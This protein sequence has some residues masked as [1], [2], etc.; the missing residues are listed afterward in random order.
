M[1]NE[2]K[3]ANWTYDAVGLGHTNV[4]ILNAIEAMLVGTGWVRPVWDTALDRCFI[5]ADRLTILLTNDLFGVAGN[6]TITE[7]DVNSRTSVSGMSG[8]T[9]QTK[10]TGTLTLDPLNVFDGNSFTIS[11]G[12]NP[13]Q[14]FEFEA[15]NAPARGKIVLTAQP[16]DGNTVVI[17][18]GV[19]PAVTFEFDSNSSVVQTG[20]LR[21]VVIGGNISVTI[22]NLSAAINAVAGTLAITANVGPLSSVLLTN[23]VGGV[24]GNV[25]LV[26]VG[27]AIYVEGM[28]GGGGTVGVTGGAVSVP[29]GATVEESVINLVS[30]INVAP[31]L[32]ITARWSDRWMF[33]GDG[34][35]QH[36]GIHVFNDTANTR[37]IIRC[38]L[39][40]KSGYGIQVETPTAHQIVIAYANTAPNTF[41]FYAGEFGFFGECGRDG[42]KVNLA[43]WLIGSYEPMPEL[44]GT[45][46]ARVHWS[47]QGAPMDLF[48]TLKFTADRNMRFVGPGDRH[49]T[50]YL[51]PLLARGH[52]ASSYDAPS[53][54]DNP[55]CAV[56]PMD[57]VL[58]IQL[59]YNTNARYCA[60]AYSFGLNSTPRDGRYRIS[61]LL[62][63]Q[64]W[65]DWFY[66]GTDSNSATVVSPATTDSQAV[67]D[68]RRWRRVP[69][70]AVTDHTLIPF[71][72]ITD[73]VTGI[74]YYI[75]QV[76]DGG[77]S[78]NLAIEYTSD[79]LSIP[80][81]P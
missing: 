72:N 34:L 25:V 23:D 52:N 60:V 62:L 38:F 13:A 3:R 29:R 6:V 30:A 4:T 54:V 57:N 64:T 48:G 31:N 45:D 77:R 15:G 51:T 70:I 44:F 73:A 7:N 43:H 22:S 12:V 33:N 8:G 68:I 81:T 18:D 69:K 61:P 2:W 1:A 71:T 55:N 28:T 40:A 59:T 42:L 26:K 63:R 79:I 36:C 80:A 5:R 17:N 35:N 65:G 46:D 74:E 21:Q 56:G 39:Q 11:D 41:Q 16:A 19:N 53:I 49:F 78:A 37:I 14:V 32:S 9:S 76:A 75:T 20:T 67:Y 58:G 27:A 47:T 50:S 10:A 66:R 24:S